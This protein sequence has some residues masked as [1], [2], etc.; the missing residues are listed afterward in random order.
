MDQ[1]ATG[2]SVSFDAK[3]N[4]A[5]L[6]G[7]VSVTEGQ[8]VVRGDKLVVDL[9]TGQ[10]RVDML[11]NTQGRVQSTFYQADHPPAAPAAA[12]KPRAAKPAIAQPLALS[13]H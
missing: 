3:S 1:V 7:N 12:P 9:T 11:D 6:L 8:N 2:N 10:A 13:T 4:T 5:T